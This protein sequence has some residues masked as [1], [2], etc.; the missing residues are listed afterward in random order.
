MKILTPTKWLLLI[1]AMFAAFV[2]TA[3]ACGGSDG[4]DGSDEGYVKAVC[5]AAN[6]F[7]A[8]LDDAEEDAEETMEDPDNVAKALE[9]VMKLMSKPF[10]D[11]ADAMDDANPP[12]DVKDTHDQMVTA[13]KSMAKQLE[14]GDL[15]ALEE[16]SDALEDFEPSQSIKDRL[17]AVAA[18]TSECKDSDFFSD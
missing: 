1:P 17:S 10:S 4:G 14:D 11:F 13:I 3:V 2:L 9:E 16:Q 12:A 18:D 6:K 15:A 5:K 8:A 7:E